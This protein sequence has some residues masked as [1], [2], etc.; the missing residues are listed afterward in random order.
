MFT[1]CRDAAAKCADTLRTV[2]TLIFFQ[3]SRLTNNMQSTASQ[4]YDLYQELQK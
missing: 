3:I 4:L 2:L 1:V